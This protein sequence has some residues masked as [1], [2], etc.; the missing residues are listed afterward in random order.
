MSFSSNKEVSLKESNDSLME[1]AI[2]MVDT[3]EHSVRVARIACE[4]AII[5]GLEGPDIVDI[6]QAALLHDVGKVNLDHTILT[7]V[8]KLTITEKKYLMNHAY[9]SSRLIK[10]FTSSNVQY[11]VKNHHEKIDGS[12]Y[13]QGNKNIGI[14]VQILVASDIYDALISDRPYRKGYE[15]A[16]VFIKMKE[17]GVSIEIIKLIKEA[18][19]NI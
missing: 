18:T 2:V 13:P 16:E 12:G 15:K 5:V 11:L 4:A 10:Q 6:V 19:K 17:E 3:M 8:G 7:K 9:F 1:Q 14:D